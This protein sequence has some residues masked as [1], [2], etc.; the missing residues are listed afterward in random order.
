MATLEIA[1]FIILVFTA[2]VSTLTAEEWYRRRRK[3]SRKPIARVN[4]TTY[5]T[6]LRI[7]GEEYVLIGITVG[8]TNLASVNETLVNAAFRSETFIPMAESVAARFTTHQEV[9][10]SS[11][12]R[13]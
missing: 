8:V 13:K 6:G 4:A 3:R 9:S 11:S 2:V 10:V 7:G 12:S 5:N 1:G